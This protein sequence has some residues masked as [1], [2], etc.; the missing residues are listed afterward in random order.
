VNPKEFYES[1]VF[2]IGSASITH[3]EIA[4]ANGSYTLDKTDFGW[5]VTSGGIPVDAD[6]DAVEDVALTL[7]T[8]QADDLIFGDMRIQGGFYASVAFTTDDGT[9]HKVGLEIE[10]SGGHPATVAG[11]N[12][13]FILNKETVRR[14]LPPIESLLKEEPES[15]DGDLQPLTV[16][17]TPTVDD[18]P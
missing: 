18:A 16:I 10:Q 13:A 2:D 9:E 7:K 12:V 6:T 11:K 1:N 3:I 14:I 4:Q 15:V 17:E 5:T 8:L